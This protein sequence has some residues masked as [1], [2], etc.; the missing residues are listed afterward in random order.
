MM[1]AVAVNMLLP[2]KLSAMFWVWRIDLLTLPV[3]VAGATAI[4]FGVR[5]LWRQK[6]AVSYLFLAWP[7]LRV[8]VPPGPQWLHVGDPRRAAR[9]P[10]GRPRSQASRNH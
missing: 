9:D 3:F 4:I 6:L 10:E 7:P 8:G 5:V 2:D 1:A